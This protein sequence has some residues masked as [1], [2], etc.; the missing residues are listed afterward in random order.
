MV[1]SVLM[2]DGMSED[3][4]QV[5]IGQWV[6]HAVLACHATQVGLLCC[7][8]LRLHSSTP[9]SRPGVLKTPQLLDSLCWLRICL[10]AYRHG[11][12]GCFVR[13]A[14]L[15]KYRCCSKANVV[16]AG[17]HVRRAGG[18]TASK[19]YKH[20][21]GS[22][23]LVHGPAS[24]CTPEDC[25]TNAGTFSAAIATFA[26]PCAAHHTRQGASSIEARAYQIP[27]RLYRAPC[28]H[29]NS[30]LLLLNADLLA[31]DSAHACKVPGAS[32]HPVRADASSGGGA[33]GR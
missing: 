17:G 7:T 9:L 2:K 30:N 18:V 15:L 4:D 6:Q 8:L 19:P 1:D 26:Q 12:C 28:R 11:D 24:R 29:P 25:P 23:S 14:G 13:L 32:R 16:Y 5:C 27:V 20:M 33:V 21:L 31:G 3:W 10:L 22:P